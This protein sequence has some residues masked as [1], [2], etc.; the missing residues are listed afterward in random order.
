M[1]QFGNVGYA[2]RMAGTEAALKS[3]TSLAGQAQR[4]STHPVYVDGVIQKSGILVKNTRKSSLRRFFFCRVYRMKQ[5][6]RI[7]IFLGRISRSY[8][9]KRYKGG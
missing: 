2:D 9:L 4:L 5:V 3:I 7:G 8:G 6:R 1:Y